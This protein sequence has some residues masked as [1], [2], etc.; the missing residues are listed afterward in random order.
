MVRYISYRIHNRKR[1]TKGGSDVLLLLAPEARTLRYYQDLNKYR[2]YCGTQ[3]ITHITINIT[4]LFPV[5]LKESPRRMCMIETKTFSSLKS[6]RSRSSNMTPLTH[7]R[8]SNPE[9]DSPSVAPEA[10]F[11][12]S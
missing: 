3:R 8:L 1:C 10:V 2:T 9:R 5:V 4:V 6:S 7:Q 11:G 12:N